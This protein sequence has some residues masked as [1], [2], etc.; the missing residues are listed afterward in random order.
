MS[1]ARAIRAELLDTRN[2]ETQS[3]PPV[4]SDSSSPLRSTHIQRSRNV[5]FEVSAHER[6]TPDLASRAW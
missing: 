2:A 4:E 6:A 3:V 5:R 1:I